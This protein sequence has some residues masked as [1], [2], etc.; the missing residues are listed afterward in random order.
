[1]QQREMALVWLWRCVF[2]SLWM[3]PF[4]W[5]AQRDRGQLLLSESQFEKSEETIPNGTYI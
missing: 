1:M 3:L 5:K 4:K 2:Y